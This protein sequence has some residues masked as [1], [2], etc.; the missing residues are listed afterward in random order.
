MSKP[1]IE[2][3]HAAASKL[4]FGPLIKT[5]ERL[6]ASTAKPDGEEWY[7]YYTVGL[8]M[9]HYLTFEPTRKGQLGTYL[10]L[11]NKGVPSADAAR[12]AV[13]GGQLATDS[14]Q[15]YDNICPKCFIWPVF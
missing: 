12:Q 3:H 15:L 9:N 5:Y 13:F 10:R 8:L 11:V 14:P 4:L 1:E 2:Q 7:G 6:L